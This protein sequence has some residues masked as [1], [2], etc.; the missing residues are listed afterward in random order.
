MSGCQSEHEQVLSV[1]NAV[2]KARIEGR[3]EPVPF[4]MH[5]ANPVVDKNEKES[6]HVPFQSMRHGAKFNL[7]PKNVT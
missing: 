3:D 5:H 1:V 6:P 7:T 4:V 2:T